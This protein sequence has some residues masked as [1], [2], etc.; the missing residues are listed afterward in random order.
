[1]NETAQAITPLLSDPARLLKIGGILVGAVL[2]GIVIQRIFASKLRRLAKRTSAAW[3]DILL[4]SMKNLLPLVFFLAALAAV[5]KF[6]P[7]GPAGLT[8]FRRALGILGIL[9]AVIFLSRLSR[10]IIHV[11]IDR[12]VDVPTALLK[13]SVSVVI[14]LLGFL[15]VLDYVGISITPLVTALGVSGVGF[16]LALQDTLGNLF[17][18]LSLLM[19]RK[20]RPGDY[21]RLDTGE[22]GVVTDIAW[23]N[24]T[25]RAP[26][27]NMVVVPNSKLAS[28]IVTNTHLP[29]KE[30]G[31]FLPVT[32][33]F[34]N[35]LALV[36]RVTIEVAREV[37]A[38]P[39]R[40]VP[41][42]EPAIRYNAFTDL[43]A[44]FSVNLRIREYQAQYAVRHD[45]YKRLHARYRREGIRLAVPPRAVTIDKPGA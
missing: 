36:E 32:V 9:C 27:S 2:L 7:F 40:T 4:D 22:E 5:L 44:R 26:E 24:T 23:R 20:F 25:I 35:D 3:D 30:M 42:F 38:G 31:L 21:V 33:A 45:F 13:N 16:A 14:Y 1:M 17:A 37:L 39:D 19:T 34:D 15:I 11:F 6:F 12:I 28:A 18:G 29:D 43:G 10:N 41:G 8:I